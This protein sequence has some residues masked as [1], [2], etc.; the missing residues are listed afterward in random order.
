[1]SAK[2]DYLAR[3]VLT[4]VLNGQKTFCTNAQVADVFAVYAST[5]PKLGHM[6]ITGFLIERDTPGMTVGK[7]IHKM[8]LRTSPMGEL[9]FDDRMRQIPDHY[10]LHARVRPKWWP[11]PGGTR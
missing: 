10:H 7:P 4:Y 8:G 3:R 5:S 6:G 11:A 1:M 9:F 2:G